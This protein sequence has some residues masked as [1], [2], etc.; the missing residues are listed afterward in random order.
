MPSEELL[1]L[2]LGPALAALFGLLFLWLAMRNERKRRLITDLPTSKTTGVFIGLVELDGRVR[3]AEP[4]ISHL[5]EE[6]C[7]L[8]RW[9]VQE[10]W[11]KWV[12]ETYRDSKGNSHTRQVHKSGWSTIDSGGD[13]IPF[14]LVDSHGAVRVIP[15]GA[16]IEAEEV[17][18]HTCGE[19]DPLYYGKGPE[20]AI[21]HSDHRRQ[22]SETALPIGVAVH[23]IGQARERMDIVAAE[24]AFN[25]DAP[26]F[27][28]TVRGERAL[29]SSYRWAVIGWWLLGLVVTLGVSMFIQPV[30]VH[31]NGM[32]AQEDAITRGIIALTG[33]FTASG[34][35]WL[36]MAHNS[37][38]ELRQ[39]VF[40]AWANID[41]QL[42][43][44]ADL[45]PNLVRIV[46][47]AGGHER[48]T[49]EAA[50]LL[51]SQRVATR[52]GKAGPDPQACGAVLVGLDEQYP[53]L[54]ADAAFRSLA[55]ALSDTEERIALA[56]G[57]VNDIAT[58]LNTRL[59]TIPDNLVA[60]LT[61]IKAQALMQADGFERDAPRIRM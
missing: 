2:L 58:H 42:K 54:R 36:W 49:L 61:G 52:P 11:S 20:E 16:D 41:V 25:R 14:E 26:L 28:I 34:M 48:S 57:Y 10:R 39:R 32:E 59:E 23:V 1:F 4:L 60:A 53:T 40:Q 21:S 51:R 9:S 37:L 18:D 12:T 22:F 33:Y 56:R 43:R 47:A 7:A 17:L 13:D 45:I 3:C 29:V 24:I 44:R 55:S 38:V 6:P 30:F 15:D 50:T 5:T 8:Y 27:V 46:E 35:G 19:D 31:S